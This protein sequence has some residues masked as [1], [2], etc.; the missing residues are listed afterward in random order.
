MA[1]KDSYIL[2]I[3][4][5]DKKYIEDREDLAAI[6]FDEYTLDYTYVN[7][8]KKLKVLVKSNEDL[9]KLK[10]MIKM[11]SNDKKYADEVIENDT[12][13]SIKNIKYNK[14]RDFRNSRPT[15]RPLRRSV[16]ESRISR[17]NRNVT[18]R[19]IRMNESEDFNERLS[20][21]VRPISESNKPMRFRRGGV[22][23]ES[24][25]E[26][27]KRRIEER[28]MNENRRILGRKSSF[29]KESEDAKKCP[30]SYEGKKIA[31]MTKAEKRSAASQVK[32]DI[33]EAQKMLK[34]REKKGLST[35]AIEAK[36]EKLQALLDCLTKK[37]E[38]KESIRSR[39]S[40]SRR[41]FES[42]EDNVDNE[43]TEETEDAEDTNDTEDTKD[44]DDT[45]DTDETED[46]DVKAITLKVLNKNVDKLKD[47][48]IEA[49]VEEDDIEV[50]DNED[51]EDDDEVGI[52]VDVNSFD[53]LKS[54]CESIGIDLEE[55]LGGEVVSDDEEEDDTT[56][57]TESVDTDDET[58]GEEDSDFTDAEMDDL[59]K[60][61]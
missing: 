41:I 19:R 30:T 59:F 45:E 12:N 48:L 32:K 53:A 14:M 57:D 6:L 8:A 34:D 51:A 23:T 13:E 7:N 9:I 26:R 24:T 27:I 44:V 18:T 35:K 40:R 3:D 31:K 37:E 50:T 47:A 10:K 61:M 15:R 33:K 49:G 16:N 58:D 36:I 21:R 20:R 55:E 52:K 56:D 39:F 11:Y 1:F 46:V 54:Y 17:L 29:L 28:R 38:I 42:E 60:D 5:F 43:E 2:S 4:K 25:R 22:L